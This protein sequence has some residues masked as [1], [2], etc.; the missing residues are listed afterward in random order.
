MFV[1][2]KPLP[3]TPTPM[4]TLTSL[5]LALVVCAVLLVVLWIV[6][7]APTRYTVLVQHT[8]RSGVVTYHTAGVR[9]GKRLAIRRAEAVNEW[10]ATTADPPSYSVIPVP[11]SALRLFRIT[12]R[13]Q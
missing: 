12:G 8:D 6:R 10:I 4:P 1:D 2:I 9:Y 11:Q 5:Y 13:F 3:Q 7:N